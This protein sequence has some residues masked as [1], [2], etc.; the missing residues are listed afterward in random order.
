MKVQIQYVVPF[1]LTEPSSHVDVYNVQG[2]IC[3]S[4]NLMVTN[5]SDLVTLDLM[6]KLLLYNV[7]CIMQ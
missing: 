1:T 3:V 6:N 4:Y 2:I 5:S 7:Y